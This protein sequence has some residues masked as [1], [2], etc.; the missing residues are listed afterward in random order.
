MLA[1]K[2]GA[3]NG[4]RESGGGRTLTGRSIGDAVLHL[5]QLRMT[6]CLLCIA[7]WSEVEESCRDKDNWPTA[8]SVGWRRWRDGLE[9]RTGETRRATH[10]DVVWQSVKSR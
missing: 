8:T 3:S 10:S 7:M 9:A 2:T 6:C 4:V 1:V 5:H